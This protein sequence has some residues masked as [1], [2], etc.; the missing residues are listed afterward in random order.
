MGAGLV[1]AMLEP[2]AARAPHGMAGRAEGS[3][4]VFLLTTAMGLHGA[5]WGHQPGPGLT[6]PLWAQ[7]PQSELRRH[8]PLTPVSPPAPHL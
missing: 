2:R 8:C 5:P 3:S 4:E 7:E 1:A 6:A